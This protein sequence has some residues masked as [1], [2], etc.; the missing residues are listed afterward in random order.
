MQA[1]A[2]LRIGSR[3]TV[4]FATVLGLLI[5]IT[6][7]AL[8][9]LGQVNTASQNFARVSA[10]ALT[11]KGMERDFLAMRRE[12][13]S[14]TFQGNTAAAESLA[15]LNQNLQ[16]A[17]G[18]LRAEIR[19]PERHAMMEELSSLADS[20]MAGF[21][22]LQD[23]QPTETRLTEQDVYGNGTQ[24][25]RTLDDLRAG[26]LAAGNMPLALA[27]GQLHED[28][29]SARFAIA[30]FLTDALDD[31]ALAT[32]RD[33]LKTVGRSAAAL[34][35]QTL[36]PEQSALARTAVDQAGAMVTGFD[37]LAA[38]ARQIDELV[39]TSMAESG[40]NFVATS[41]RLSRNYADYLERTL[42]SSK[43]TA[44]SSTMLLWTAGI[45]ALLTGI[46]AALLISR[47]IVRPIQGITRVMGVL[48]GGDTKA[49]VPNRTGRDEVGEMARAVQVF[50]EAMIETERLRAAQ[51][52]QERRAER[53]RRAALKQMADSLEQSVKSV[54]DAV[55]AASTEL[56][57]SAQ[58]M[59]GTAVRS[60]AEAGTAAA[61]AQQASANVQTVAAATEELTSS[62]SE[63]ARQV[64]RQA[65]LALAATRDAAQSEDRVKE[66]AEDA[67]NISDVIGLINAI[68]GQTNLLALNATIEAA[69]AGEAGKGFAVVASEVKALATQTARATEQIAER[70]RAVQERTDGTVESIAQIASR[71]EEMKEI[72]TAVASAVE[73]QT[74]A[75][76]EISRNANEAA[77]G[78]EAVS[79]SLDAVN[80]AA[81]EAGAASS[82]VTASAE[83]LAKQSER[84]RQSVDSFIDQVR[85]A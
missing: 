12:V 25:G 16:A 60:S 28:L 52:E 63:I 22:R 82:Q 50:K 19:D 58:S 38:T 53:E 75:T 49:E 67:R 66:L 54:V 64:Q 31:K 3:I 47:S 8:T 29:L 26:A 24:A 73:Q 20:Y 4:G 48:A 71:V 2:R 44:A 6:A 23:L 45:I 15:S 77:S 37:A 74:A 42:A 51:I 70:I 21:S 9:G 85:A 18:R 36:S 5:V 39:T 68:A 46:A 79:R 62:I 84:L 80:G 40:R 34:S 27:A 78:T 56:N 61:A 32:A 35:Q 7:V 57:A 43:A 33:R 1:L 59:S 14:F 76:Q 17:A 11:T 10:Q 55:S 81:G 69:R 41:E 13:L 72:A 65:E 30:A 83:D